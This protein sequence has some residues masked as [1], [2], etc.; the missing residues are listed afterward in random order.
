[1]APSLTGTY[2]TILKSH[3]L[4]I[5][6]PVLQG[7]LLS[8]L[9]VFVSNAYVENQTKHE[10][11]IFWPIG[12]TSLI[13]FD[14]CRT[15]YID[16]SS[17]PKTVT[18]DTVDYSSG[19]GF[20]GT[21]F[22]APVSGLYMFCYT[23]MGDNMIG[24]LYHTRNGAVIHARGLFTG[25]LHSYYRTGSTQA[26]VE[27][28]QGDM[29]YVQLRRNNNSATCYHDTCTFIGYLIKQLWAL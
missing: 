18:W 25:K 22:T 19:G 4:K 23:L 10:H 29:V 27:L 5:A 8:Y 13:A 24:D 17:S 9:C 16:S 11:G 15:S 2:P 6:K 7:I 14:A 28:K 26:L 3:Q 20:N 12:S 1:M 21:H